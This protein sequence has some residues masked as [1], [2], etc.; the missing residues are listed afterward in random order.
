MQI[1][2]LSRFFTGLPDLVPNLIYL[3]LQPRFKMAAKRTGGVY[4][5]WRN[6]LKVTYG[7]MVLSFRKGL[8]RP[9]LVRV[10][11]ERTKVEF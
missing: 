9:V 8:Y 4:N 7:T 11:F 5:A 3:V 2:L 1:I 10:G 6:I